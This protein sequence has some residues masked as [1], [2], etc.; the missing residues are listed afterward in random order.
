MRAFVEAA[1]DD[2]CQRIFATFGQLE[3][4]L[5]DAEF[6]GCPFVAAAGEYAVPG[7][8][9]D[10]V[11]QQARLHKRLFLAYFEELVRAAR[12]AEPK[13]V[14]QQLIF[15]HEGAIAFAQVLGAEGVAASARKAAEKLIGVSA[16]S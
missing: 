13:L 12:I 5:K 8:P 6:K 11:F 7:A 3:I 10:P 15:L 16:A 9:T 1:S 4:W 14:A 2:P